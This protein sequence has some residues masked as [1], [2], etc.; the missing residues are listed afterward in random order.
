MTIM[1]YIQKK[2]NEKSVTNEVSK[3]LKIIDVNEVHPLNIDFIV[4]LVKNQTLI[5][6]FLLYYLNL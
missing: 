5:N 2:R 6:L 3:L 1:H 4:L